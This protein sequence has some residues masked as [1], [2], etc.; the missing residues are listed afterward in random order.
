MDHPISEDSLKRF[1]AGNS[2]REE[3]RTV[4]AHLM[5]GCH[6]CARVLKEIVQPEALA[7]YD[8]ALDKFEEALR[9]SVEEPVRKASSSQ[10]LTS[11]DTKEMVLWV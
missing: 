8:E 5:K 10:P 4:V 7:C 6:E 3:A 11:G 1:A 2:P 9:E